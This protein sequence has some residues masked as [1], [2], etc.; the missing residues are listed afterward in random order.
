MKVKAI[1]SRGQSMTPFRRYIGRRFFASWAKRRDQVTTPKED[2]KEALKKYEE[3]LEKY[4]MSLQE[5]A[6]YNRDVNAD[7]GSPTFKD[8]NK[9][10]FG[11][12]YNTPFVKTRNEPLPLYESPQPLLAWNQS[13]GI[14]QLREDKIQSERTKQVILSMHR[15]Y[16]HIWSI[17]NLCRSLGISREDML[18]IFWEDELG[19]KHKLWPDYD[20]VKRHEEYHGTENLVESKAYTFDAYNDVTGDIGFM[21]E[22]GKTPRIVPE[23]GLPDTI[24]HSHRIHKKFSP[25]GKDQWEIVPDE[26]TGSGKKVKQMLDVGS[27]FRPQK[28]AYMI[29][30]FS[31]MYE[32]NWQ[33][34][35]QLDVKVRERDGTLRYATLEEFQWSRR[36]E[37]P[38]VTYAPIKKITPPV[39]AGTLERVDGRLKGKA[40]TGRTQRHVADPVAYY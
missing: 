13:K 15:R 8:P 20:N 28:A 31:K 3:D 36:H 16:P 7:E 33:A 23:E 25:L 30:N 18:T 1:I 14:Y 22:G 2:K 12:R 37:M 19:R 34:K 38:Q 11:T 6:Q 35:S 10:E 40:F 24:Y 39:G 5:Q 17:P 21:P 9:I 29:R 4:Y 26:G 27:S 32:K